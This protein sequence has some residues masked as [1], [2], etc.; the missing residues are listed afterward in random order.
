VQMLVRP[1]QTSRWSPESP[2]EGNA[3]GKRAARHT[4]ADIEVLTALPSDGA[5]LWL[6][7]DDEP[8]LQREQSG[9]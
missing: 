2:T 6:A 7:G 9:G 1:G 8:P 5:L 3:G 4:D